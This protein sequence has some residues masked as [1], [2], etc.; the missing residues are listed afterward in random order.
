M[1]WHDL[2]LALQSIW[3][4]PYL[5][6]LIILAL[7]AGVGTSVIAM[8]LYH[9]RAGNPIWWKNDRLFR[10][11]V[12]SRPASTDIDKNNRHPEYPPFVMT[13]QDASAIYRAGISDR[14]LIMTSSRGLLDPSLPQR[15]PFSV[16][17][18]M[19]SGSFFP[20]FDVPF[21]YGQ[22]WSQQEDDRTAPVAVISRYVNHKVFGGGNSIGKS[23]ILA[24]RE[25]RV[26]GVLDT[27][28]PQPRFYDVGQSFAASDDVFIPFGWVAQDI[29]P[30]GG[31]CQRTQTMVSS[32]RELAGAECIWLDVWVEI[33]SQKKLAAYRQFLDNYASSQRQRGRFERKVNNR[34]VDVQT[35]LQMNDVI[36]TESRVEAVLGLIFLFICVLNT[37]GLLLAKFTSLA[38]IS[39]LRRALGASR[40][41]IIRQHLAEVLI[42]ALLAGAAGLGI[43]LIGLRLIQAFFFS[44]D[45]AGADNPDIAVSAQALSHL[46]G[47]MMTFALGLA[48]L[49]GLAAGVYP[50]VF[51]GR[52]PPGSLLKAL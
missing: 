6:G 39:A 3:R 23:L 12:D 34:L 48:V 37:V 36:G 40:T 44:V 35:W 45:A 46:D 30:V 16:S 27:W 26:V 24:G 7:A 52:R 50:A 8:T 22:A 28:L 43:A 41:D 32:F 21:Q 18:R 25:F 15:R 42:M 4:T 47:P 13:Y 17:V 49:S 9:D 14:S 20:M 5:S 1:I 2:Q 33:S 51:V 10:V 29:L 38:S 11:M 19:T 31:F